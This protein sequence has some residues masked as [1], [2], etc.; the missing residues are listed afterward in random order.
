MHLQVSIR[1]DKKAQTKP[2]ETGCFVYMNI[3]LEFLIC[4][5]G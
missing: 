5:V 1:Y 4:F 2:S 3:L